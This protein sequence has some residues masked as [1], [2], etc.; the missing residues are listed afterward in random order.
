MGAFLLSLG[1]VILVADILYLA[2][3]TTSSGG[4]DSGLFKTGLTA[5]AVC[6]AGGAVMAIVARAKSVITA[7]SCPKCGR[8]VAH[9]RMFCDDHLA[10]TIN[11][12][13]D[14]QRHK[15]G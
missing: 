3:W 14:E 2:V 15:D 12:Y 1:G 8:K 11:R 13:R 4:A 6:F 5:A 7:K 9:G 10:E